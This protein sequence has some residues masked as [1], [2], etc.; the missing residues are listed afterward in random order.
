MK[1]KLMGHSIEFKRSSMEVTRNRLEVDEKRRI[2][3]RIKI[4]PDK[5]PKVSSPASCP[6]NKPANN[7][8]AAEPSS[9]NP[10]AIEP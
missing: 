1:G 8:T 5:H 4:A 9:D 10:P 3:D 2:L 7:C 6:L